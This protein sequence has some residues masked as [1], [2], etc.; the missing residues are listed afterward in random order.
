M[1]EKLH[2]NTDE[3]RRIRKLAAS[4][5]RGDDYLRAMAHL[6]G[7][8]HIAALR[9]VGGTWELVHVGGD[10]YELQRKKQKTA[11]LTQQHKNR[12]EAALNDPGLQ[13]I[14]AGMQLPADS[15]KSKA[16]AWDKLYDQTSKEAK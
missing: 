14:G 8:A 1:S 13:K 7:D 9:C 15:A 6:K 16:D 5:L 4:G 11:E 3:V 12:E 2:L 10:A